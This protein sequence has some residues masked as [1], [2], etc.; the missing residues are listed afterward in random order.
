MLW[1]TIFG[2]I[3]IPL[4]GW[5]FN[6]LITNKSNAQDKRIDYL[7]TARDVDKKEFYLQLNGLRASIEKDY[8]LQKL[9]DQ[10]I[11]SHTENNDQRHAS[12][13]KMVEDQF[14]HFGEKID[15]LKQAIKDKKGD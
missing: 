4:I 14:K 12:L 8:V 6:T 7:E 3:V 15:E 5:I 10:T 2:I 11:K 13:L 9:Y 1:V